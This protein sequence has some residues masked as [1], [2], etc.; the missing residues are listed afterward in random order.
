MILF[1]PWVA[2]MGNIFSVFSMLEY[3]KN[4]MKLRMEMYFVI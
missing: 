2:E 4:D 3:L 1:I